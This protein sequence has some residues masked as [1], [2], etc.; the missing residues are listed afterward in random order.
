VIGRIRD[1]PRDS[2]AKRLSMA[3][4]LIGYSRQLDVLMRDE[5]TVR[6]CAREFVGRQLGVLDADPEVVRA[7]PS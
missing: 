6:E 7:K 1:L 2:A 4:R 3:G 5:A